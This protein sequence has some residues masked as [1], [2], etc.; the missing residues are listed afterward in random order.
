M[1]VMYLG[2]L[3]LKRGVIIHGE[4]LRLRPGKL[5]LAGFHVTG[6]FISHWAIFSAERSAM[7]WYLLLLPFQ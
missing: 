2:K 5:M 3:F 1:I 7:D 4:V 6:P